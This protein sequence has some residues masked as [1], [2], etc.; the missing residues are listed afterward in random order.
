[1][2]YPWGMKLLHSVQTDFWGCLFLLAVMNV[3]DTFQDYLEAEII[4]GNLW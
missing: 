1:M 2:E 3:D 4:T